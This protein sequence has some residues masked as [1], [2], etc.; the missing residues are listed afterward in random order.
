VTRQTL[1]VR[2]FGSVTNDFVF[3]AAKRWGN[4]QFVAWLISGVLGVT[5][6]FGVGI[7][8]GWGVGIALLV[9]G[10]PLSLNGLCLSNW[11]LIRLLFGQFGKESKLTVF[12]M[13]QLTC[14][15]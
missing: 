12:F 11:S 7:F 15:R 2:L 3:H 14:A 8:R 13:T 9:L 6:L 10:M 1:A 4:V 5:S